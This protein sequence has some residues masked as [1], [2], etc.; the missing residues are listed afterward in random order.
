LPSAP[1]P[2]T[3]APATETHDLHDRLEQALLAQR[4]SD[5]RSGELERQID[6]LNQRLRASQEELTFFRQARPGKH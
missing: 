4:L 2:Q 5:A 3:A 6:D 1:L